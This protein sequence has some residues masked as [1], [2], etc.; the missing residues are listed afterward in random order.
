MFNAVAAIDAGGDESMK[1]ILLMVVKVVGF[2]IKIEVQGRKA[3]VRGA[4]PGS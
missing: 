3:Q 1:S 4:L 2:G